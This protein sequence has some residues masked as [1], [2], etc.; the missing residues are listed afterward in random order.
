[1]PPFWPDSGGSRSAA[2]AHAARIRT[3]HDRASGDRRKLEMRPSRCNLTRISRSKG[4]HS[5]FPAV[6]A[7]SGKIDCDPSSESTLP[8]V[9]EP[10]YRRQRG[11]HAD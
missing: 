3:L 7:E 6:S 9:Y 1:M 4:V 10:P 2:L 11:R 5:A 8:L